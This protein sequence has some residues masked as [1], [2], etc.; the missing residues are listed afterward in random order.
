MGY[1]VCDVIATPISAKNKIKTDRPKN[2]FIA[3]NIVYRNNKYMKQ[4]LVSVNMAYI[5]ITRP[6]IKDRPRSLLYR[7][8][9]LPHRLR[10]LAEF[11]KTGRDHSGRD[12]ERPRSPD[13]NERHLQNYEYTYCGSVYNYCTIAYGFVEIIMN[14]S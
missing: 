4:L 8:N 3:L 11:T 2:I 1:Y 13:I 5:T 10:S 7:P 9:S 12:P 14:F 6:I